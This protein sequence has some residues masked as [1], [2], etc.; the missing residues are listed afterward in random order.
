MSTE[1]SLVLTLQKQRKRIQISFIATIQNLRLK[2]TLSR[3]QTTCTLIEAAPT[4]AQAK[5]MTR[6]A[7]YGKANSLATFSVQSQESL[8][9]SVSY[10]Y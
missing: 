10:L 4:Q 9:Y 5:T 2:T 3:T 7:Q 8:P 1:M 6:A